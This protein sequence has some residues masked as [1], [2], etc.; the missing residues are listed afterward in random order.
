MALFSESE[1]AEVWDRR[2]LP[3]AEVSGRSRPNDRDWGG[4]G[5][6]LTQRCGAA[7]PGSGR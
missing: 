4:S 1:P 6:G 7:P 2:P 3:P 5:A